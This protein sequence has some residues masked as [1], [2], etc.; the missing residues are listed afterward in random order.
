MGEAGFS[1]RTEGFALSS[2]GLEVCVATNSVIARSRPKG[3]RR[4]NPALVQ[5]FSASK[6]SIV[7]LN[8]KQS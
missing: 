7:H 3:A 5:V 2:L 8:N 4:G 6:I 1:K